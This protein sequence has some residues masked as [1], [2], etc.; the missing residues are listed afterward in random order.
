VVQGYDPAVNLARYKALHT[1][2]E[3][4]E[5]A[6][7]EEAVWDEM[8]GRKGTRVYVTSSFGDVEDVDH[9]PAMIEWLLDQHA[10]FRGAIEAI[11]GLGRSG[12]SSRSVTCAEYSGLLLHSQ[13]F[14]LRGDGD[15][16]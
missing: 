9:W 3:H 12:R 7:G 4:F 2:K 6:L 1:K 11:G 5:Q 15:G 14:F 16:G 13:H 10:R 8:A